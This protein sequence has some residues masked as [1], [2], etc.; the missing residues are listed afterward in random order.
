MDHVIPDAVL[1]DLFQAA[2]LQRYNDEGVEQ[3]L[4]E[5]LA[6][7]YWTLIRCLNRIAAGYV[8]SPVDIANIAK[9]AGYGTK[10]AAADVP[11]AEDLKAAWLN[12][13]FVADD[14]VTVA[15]RGGPRPAR[16]KRF[17]SGF[18]EMVVEFK[19]GREKQVDV[20]TVK[21]VQPQ[22]AASA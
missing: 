1:G 6:L 18:T 5:P 11:P 14:W 17:A 15:W 21:R 16:F 2:G 4:P 7:E 12:K 9:T 10:K 8:L 20:K 3:E 13:E 19:D 22:E